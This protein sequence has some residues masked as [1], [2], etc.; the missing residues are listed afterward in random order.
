M[1]PG[2]LPPEPASPSLT[3]SLEVPSPHDLTVGDLSKTQIWPG[4]LFVIPSVVLELLHALPSDLAPVPSWPALQPLPRT[5]ATAEILG[6][7]PSPSVGPSTKM[8]LSLYL[9][10]EILFILQNLLH[11]MKPFL[12]PIF[13]CRSCETWASYCFSF[14]IYIMAMERQPTS[15]NC[16]D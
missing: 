2:S 6:F 13:T 3:P 7:H 1:I 11:E 5:T 14:L 10:R 9:S 8:P 16:C 12:T 15:Q 4:L